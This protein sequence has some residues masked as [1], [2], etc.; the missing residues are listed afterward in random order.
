MCNILWAPTTKK[1]F[2]AV[3]KPIQYSKHRHNNKRVALTIGIV[4]IISLAIGLPIVLGLNNS[5]DRIPQLC[6]FY[7]SDFII[8]S[9]LGSFYIPCVLMVF[10][11]WRIFRAIRDRA[12]KPIGSVKTPAVAAGADKA[13]VIENKSQTTRL[14]RD[15]AG[16]PDTGSV[17]GGGSLPRN[18]RLMDRMKRELPL[19][20]ETDA[21]TNTGSYEGDEDMEDNSDEVD[22]IEGKVIRNE[23]ALEYQMVPIKGSAQS[24]SAAA[25]PQPPPG[26]RLTPSALSEKDMTTTTNGTNADSGYLTSTIDD[27][28]TQT[29][30]LRPCPGSPMDE[31]PTVATG[32]NPAGGSS[33]S[34]AHCSVT[35]VTIDCASVVP[36]NG[37]KRSRFNLGRKHKSSKKKREKLCNRRERKATKTL[38]IVLGVFLFCWVPF[39]TCNIMD[40]ICMKLEKDCRLSPTAFL[41]TTWLGYLNSIVNPIIYTIFN[42]QFRDAFKKM[43]G[44]R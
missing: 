31:E 44:L 4:W 20:T 19:I 30:H 17:G 3:T 2:I 38:A 15:T 10:L 24:F 8:Y 43:L 34:S 41:L 12:K 29:Y 36:V 21:V 27:N 11:Y 32:A 26:D 14:T 25:T 18:K 13:L 23:A 39:F 42:L 9:S 33:A 40:A 35:T 16:S 5:V 28:S 37:K 6:M 1:R 22:R 7:N